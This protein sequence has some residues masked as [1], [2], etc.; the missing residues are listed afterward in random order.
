MITQIFFRSGKE[1]APP[2]KTDAPDAV[3]FDEQ[4][5]PAIANGAARLNEDEVT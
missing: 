2:P 4:V 5:I 1:N 3:P